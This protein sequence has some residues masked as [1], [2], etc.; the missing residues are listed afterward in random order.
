[1][2]QAL[3]LAIAV[4]AV[5]TVSAQTGAAPAEDGAKAVLGL[6]NA[7][8]AALVKGDAVAF[9][10]ML[11]D[12]F[13]YSENDQ[14]MDRASVLAA[15]T[16][17]AET[18]EAARNE[19]MRLHDYGA[20]AAVTGWLVVR[21]HSASGPFERRYRYTD[22]W[23]RRGG[24]WTI[25]VAHDYLVPAPPSIVG[26]WRGASTCVKDGAHPACKDEAVVYR[27]K[28]AP[29]RAGVVVLDAEKVVESHGVPMYSLEFTY[30]AK[31]DA[32]ASEFQGPG[33]HGVWSYVVRGDEM[34]GTL[35]DLPSRRLVR[36]VFARRD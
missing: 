27:F 25:V 6:E 5:S 2:K 12:D 13:V 31:R 21:G 15:L 26:T 7:W 4:V 16:S 8:T 29:D 33:T 17:G 32:W 9:R 28:H 36:H 18:I 34:M 23:M 1:M 19:E 11:A 30:D 35:V 22:I 20:A 14:T 24:E 3:V 10:R